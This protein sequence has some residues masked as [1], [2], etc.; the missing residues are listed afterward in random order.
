MQG[1]G[2]ERSLEPPATEASETTDSV[3]AEV[4]EPRG[5]G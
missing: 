4:K 5:K 1:P 2:R 3:G